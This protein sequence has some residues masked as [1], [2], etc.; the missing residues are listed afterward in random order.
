M[1]NNAVTSS[2]RTRKA[3]PK[4]AVELG[5]LR[6]EQS[7]ELHTR[8][9]IALWNGEKTDTSTAEPVRSGPVDSEQIITSEVEHSVAQRKGRYFPHHN[10]RMVAQAAMMIEGDIKQDNPFADYWFDRLIKEVDGL[11]QDIADKLEHLN[12]F[13]ES[14]LPAS[15]SYSN[16]LSTKPVTFS[17]RSGSVIYYRFLF[18]V[19]AIDKYVTRVMQAT[20][21]GVITTPAK[22]SYLGEAVKLC[23]SAIS[24]CASYR[25]YDVDRN[26]IAANNQRA[27]DAFEHYKKLQIIPTQEHI[28]GTVRNQFAP[29]IHSS[30][31]RSSGDR[32]QG[33]FEAETT[34]TLNV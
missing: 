27:R 3:A 6:S 14:K 32:S 4:R 21:Y 13:L 26:D 2:V 12:A 29:E 20:H 25:L 5:K 7:I 31:Q 30:A 1:T 34:V 19:L 33:Y 23:R 11:Q 17:V 9:G 18:L 8:Q 28:E 10:M 16:A 24:M 15:F 22:N